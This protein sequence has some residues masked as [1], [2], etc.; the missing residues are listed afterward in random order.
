MRV[1]SIMYAEPTLLSSIPAMHKTTR[2]NCVPIAAACCSL[3]V[4]RSLY[5]V[6]CSSLK[7]TCGPNISPGPAPDPILDCPPCEKDSIGIHPGNRASMLSP[8]ISPILRY[9]VAI[10][11]ISFPAQNKGRANHPSRFV[12]GR[13]GEWKC[14][15]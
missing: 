9:A 14:Y 8:L 13:A 12:H 1:F 7:R 11:L 10:K 6:T 5:L 4:E 15:G 2:S 3:T